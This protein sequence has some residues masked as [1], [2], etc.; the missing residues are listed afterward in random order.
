MAM[1]RLN[2][3]EQFGLLL[4]DL[5]EAFLDQTV[6]NFVDF[7][8]RNM[9]PRRQFQS[10]ETRMPDQHEIGSRLIRIQPKLL[11]VCARIAENPSREVL[12]SS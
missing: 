10:L 12:L 9:R 7:L 11:Q 1:A 6:E 3:G 2:G 5:R 8:P 4:D